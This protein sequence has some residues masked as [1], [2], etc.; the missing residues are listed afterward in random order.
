MELGFL[1]CSLTMQILP[2]TGAEQKAIFLSCLGYPKPILQDGHTPPSSMLSLFHL[3][4]SEFPNPQVLCSGDTNLGLSCPTT[5][6]AH[7]LM[8]P[9]LCSTTAD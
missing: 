1:D 6:V 7:T 8:S 3:L 4:Q 9:R 5:L 2:V